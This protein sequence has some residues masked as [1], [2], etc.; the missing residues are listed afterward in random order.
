MSQVNPVQQTVTIAPYGPYPK[1]TGSLWCT[2]PTFPRSFRSLSYKTFRFSVSRKLLRFGCVHFQSAVS[3]RWWGTSS[4]LNWSAL[5]INLQF[6]G[7]GLVISTTVGYND[8]M[9]GKLNRTRVVASLSPRTVVVLSASVLSK[10]I[11][12]P[13]V[14]NYCST[15]S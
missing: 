14:L 6:R 12:V 1:N 13:S 11:V 10:R 2:F 15:V 7:S 9:T 4:L 3:H 5:S 8:F